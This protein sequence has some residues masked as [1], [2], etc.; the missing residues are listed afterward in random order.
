MDQKNNGSENLV[1]TVGD[2]IESYRSLISIRVAEHT[3]QGIS[4]S[5]MGVLALIT[6]VFVLLFVGIGSAWWLG[7]YL[8]NMKVGFFIV[9]GF[10]LLILLILLLASRKVLIPRIRNMIIKDMYEKD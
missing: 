1:S 10:Y 5:I 7:E 8:N 4:V 3:S 6:S 2:L 9:G